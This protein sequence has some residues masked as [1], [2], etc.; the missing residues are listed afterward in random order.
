VTLPPEPA[1][2]SQQTN[3]E[4][5]IGAAIGTGM[6]QSLLGVL[7]DLYVQKPSH[8]VEEERHYTTLAL[9]LIEEADP[10]TKTSGAAQ[11]ASYANAPP[12]V[13]DRLETKVPISRPRSLL[14]SH[15][16]SPPAARDTRMAPAPPNSQSEPTP[17]VLATPDFQHGFFDAEPAER[18]RRMTAVTGATAINLLTVPHA[19]ECCRRLESAALQGRP[20]DFIALLQSALS[21]ATAS[22]ERIVNDGSGEPLVIAAKALAMPI[23]MLQRILL[24]VNPVIAHSVKRVFDLSALY[25]E[26]TP[27]TAVLAVKQWQERVTRTD[28][29]H[30]APGRDA[31]ARGT[32]THAAR[33]A[34]GLP[35]PSSSGRQRTS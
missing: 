10:R 22:A 6:R 20:H 17:M 15:A 24:L 12:A 23:D 1:A 34:A 30:G 5:N 28:A 19:K 32:A 27:A 26:I 2:E 11:L 8:S 16:S 33:P 14:A 25:D 18:R 4:T 35:G 29:A 21:I 13:T 3:R 7:T 31:S 9:R